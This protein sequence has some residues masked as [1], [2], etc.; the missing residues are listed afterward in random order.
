MKKKK[1]PVMWLWTAI[2]AAGIIIDQLT[3]LIVT[4]N[5][6]LYSS[7]PF[8]PKIIEFRY[9]LNRGAAWGMFS[10]NRW[11]FLV[12][13][14]AALVALPILLYKYRNLHFLFGFSLSLIIGGAAG[15]MIDRIF[16]GAVVDFLNFLFIDFPVFNFA[17]ICVTVGAALMFVY[18]IF[19]DK[20]IFRDGKKQKAENPA[21]S[22]DENE[23]YSDNK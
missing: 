4:K 7:A 10:E 2:I 8:I 13:S 12:I 17:D 15:N 20:E 16:S 1:F 18:L 3:K 9:I 19:I 5:M 14:A 11:I 23:N 22:G 21:S 6:E